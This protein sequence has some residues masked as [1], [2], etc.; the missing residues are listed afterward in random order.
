MFKRL[1]F[2][3][4]TFT[5]INKYKIYKKKDKFIINKNLKGNK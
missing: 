5:V 1:N 3:K 2:I 4:K